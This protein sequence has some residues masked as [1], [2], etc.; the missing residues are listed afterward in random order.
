METFVFHDKLNPK[1]SVFLL[2]VY[3]FHPELLPKHHPGYLKL[4]TQILVVAL[5]NRD[6]FCM[7]KFRMWGPSVSMD[8]I[9]IFRIEKKAF[10]TR[11]MKY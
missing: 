2:F 11:K 7:G 8:T 1:Q 4:A 10:T 6:S 9:L 3:L 5:S